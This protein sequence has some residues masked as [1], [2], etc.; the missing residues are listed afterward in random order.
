M[1]PLALPGVLRRF[2]RAQG[3]NRFD[4]LPAIVP[5]TSSTATLAWVMSSTSG[6]RICPLALRTARGLLPRS[7]RRDSRYGT[8]SSRR[9]CPFEGLVLANR[10]YRIDSPPPLNLQLL[11]DTLF[12][13]E[14]RSG[15]REPEPC[16]ILLD[17]HLPR[18]DG[19]AVL[20]AM[21]E[22]PQLEHIK[23][24]VLSGQVLPG[25]RRK[26]LARGVL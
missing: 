11:W 6:S 19:I 18:Y 1:S 7:W 24:L 15:I 9:W 21:R 3:Q 5:I 2:L 14:H 12:V 4:G 8:F 23:I 13:Q 16:V 10:F 25:K 17:L 22:A 20:H 26:W